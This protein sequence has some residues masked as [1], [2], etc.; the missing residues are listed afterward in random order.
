MGTSISTL[1]EAEVIGKNSKGLQSVRTDE[2]PTDKV[3]IKWGVEPG[4]NLI[5]G[6]QTPE[7]FRF[8]SKNREKE[9]LRLAEHGLA[10]KE[11][12]PG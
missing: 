4:E 1:N 5:E 3:H 9:I 12:T 8:N 6:Y 7:E 10:R 2:Q 11:E